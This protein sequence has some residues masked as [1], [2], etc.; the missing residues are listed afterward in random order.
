MLGSA[1]PTNVTAR[2]HLSPVRLS[3]VIFACVLA[4]AADASRYQTA[5]FALCGVAALVAFICVRPDLY[6]IALAAALLVPYTWSP[7]LLRAPAP[8]IMLLA[9]PGGFTAIVA[10]ALRGRARLCVLDYLV[11][12]LFLS[13]LLSEVATPSSASILSSRTLSHNYVEVILLPYLAFRLIL[14]AWPKAALSNLP[15]ALMITGAG[16]SLV[17]IVEELTHTNLFA[18]SSLNNPELTVW[19][20]TF[21]RDSGVR[22]DASM[23][24]PIAL[25]SFLIIPLVLAFG[26]RRWGLFAL[27]ALGEVLTLS[28]G[29][30]IAVL[31]ALL[32]CGILT[33]RVGRLLGLIAVI[34]AL[35]VLIGPVRNSVTNT[36]Q[37]GTKEQHSAN[38][39]SEL[40]G[41]SLRSL[42]FWGKP[43][44]E[45]SALFA[46][47]EVKLPDVTSEL[48]L[49][50]GRQGV[51]GLTLW[52]MLLMAF[53]YVIREAKR[54]GDQLLLLLGVA[55]VGEWI[56][57]LSV[58]L[59]TSYQYA[60]WLTV[61]MAAV[62]LSTNPTPEPASQSV[63]SSYTNV[64]APTVAGATV[65]ANRFRPAIPLSERAR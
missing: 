26:Q 23:G 55:L 32:L 22:A 21:L 35:A 3:L 45:T 2:R 54:R 56:T 65:R 44:G 50:A 6:A 4:G 7:T 1:N 49:I 25:G 40:I 59:I 48:A 11:A 39:R 16:L 31:A 58:A 18:H 5:V 10:L 20:Q 33:H 42:T 53:V 51:P 37:T 17:A 41:T 14:S 24:H 15:S 61:A 64:D 34:A 36:F 38:Y 52:V 30:Y 9:L 62:R 28:R 29:P 47:S 12:A 46:E 27:L 8:A 13:A 57:L 43:T 19:E 63:A 60:F